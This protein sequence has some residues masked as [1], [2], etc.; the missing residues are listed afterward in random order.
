M[1]LRVVLTFIAGILVT[2]H[3][4]LN[5]R[6]GAL[7]GSAVA[8]NAAFWIVGALG[9]CAAALA[10]DGPAFL[11]KAAAAPLHLAVSG[12][13]GAAIALY[14]ARSV[15]KLGI[16]VFTLLMIAGQIFASAAASR[17]GLLGAAQESLGEQRVAGL[18][19]VLGGCALYLFGR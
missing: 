19:M 7:A 10:A 18:A 12:T 4:S 14:S 6:A 2:V 8:S 13:M 11:G 5:A 3:L 9:A 17:A 15:P 1:V 16:A